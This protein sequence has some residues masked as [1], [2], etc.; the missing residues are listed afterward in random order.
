M[1]TAEVIS[2]HAF[3]RVIPRSSPSVLSGAFRGLAAKVVYFSIV[4]T[5]FV[6][7]TISGRRVCLNVL[8]DPS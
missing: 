5:V 7:V 3:P 2:A 1:T 6:F 4:A 8:F